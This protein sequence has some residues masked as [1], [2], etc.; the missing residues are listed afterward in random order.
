MID[1]VMH[2]PPFRTP[3]RL[4]W[5][6]PLFML[7]ALIGLP[8]TLL[9]F[10]PGI[11][12]IPVAGLPLRQ[13]AHRRWQRI[14]LR[15]FGVR[16]LVEG[17]LPD[18]PALIVANHISWLDIVLLQS[19][20]PMWLVAKAEI[21]AWPLIGWL[22]QAGGTLFIV[23]GRLE[24]RRKIIRRMG[25]LMRRGERVGIF[26]EGGIRP[27]RGVGRFHAPLFAPAIRTRMPVVPVAIRYERERD[28]HE[29]FVFGPRE[30]FLRNFF[31][32]MSEPP[33]TGRL[34]IGAPIL[35]YDSGRRRLAEKAGAVVKDFYDNA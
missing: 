34:M 20:W 15:L 35:D 11:N 3:W 8:L 1:P 9:C 33:L 29:E 23:R 10:L 14:T 18:G 30:G 26:P 2:P 22:A 28:L 19:L 25:A 4:I 32:L 13:R 17:R 27:E 16:M 7:H 6:L 12:R 21:R 31:R 24:S 5:R